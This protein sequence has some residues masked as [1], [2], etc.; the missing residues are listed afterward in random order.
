M[1]QRGFRAAHISIVWCNTFSSQKR[2]KRWMDFPWQKGF[3][4]PIG[5]VGME[6]SSVSR[7]LK[8]AESGILLLHKQVLRM[9]IRG[10]LNEEEIAPFLTPHFFRHG[11]K[12]EDLIF[13]DN[14]GF[15]FPTVG[16]DKKDFASVEREIR[17]AWNPLITQL[18]PNQSTFF[19][20]RQQ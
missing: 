13:H 5:E 6:D 11:K 7:K 4:F 12:H 16:V 2:K 19:F 20:F 8:S 18:R 9:C 14:G 1:R 17:G 15:W 10:I 3:W